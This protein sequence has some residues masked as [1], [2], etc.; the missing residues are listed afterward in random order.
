VY[1]FLKIGNCSLFNRI[2][3]KNQ[4]KFY[5]RAKSNF[6]EKL[7]IEFP[8]RKESLDNNYLDNEYEKKIINI[9]FFKNIISFFLIFLS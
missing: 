9:F 4:R 7:K 8:K 5:L 2:A 1:R 3:P 6:S